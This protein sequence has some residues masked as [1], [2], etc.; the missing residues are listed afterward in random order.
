MY[1]GRLIKVIDI[2][3]MQGGAFGGL[4]R[5]KDSCKLARNG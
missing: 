1:I 2:F 4:I 5:C 3:V